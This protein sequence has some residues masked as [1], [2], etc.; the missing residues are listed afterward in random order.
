MYEI[1]LP[2]LDWFLYGNTYSG[3]LRADPTKGC[4]CQTTFNYRVRVIENKY[5]K[6]IA[7]MCFFVLPWNAAANMD[8]M[9]VG[10]F[11]VT[12]FGLET[13][14]NWIRSKFITELFA[15]MM[16]SERLHL[17]VSKTVRYICR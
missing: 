7:A 8:E 13:A 15:P 3:S 1:K 2:T 5:G 11:E 4:L 10:R 14:E 6:C 9:V 12:S 16:L 17:D